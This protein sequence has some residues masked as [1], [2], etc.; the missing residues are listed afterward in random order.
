MRTPIRMVTD[1]LD[2][3]FG[4]KRPHGRFLE[5]R[6]PD[7][8]KERLNYLYCFGGITF[9]LFL[10]LLFTGLL[11]SVYYSPSEEHAYESIVR[12]QE[13]VF[14]GALIRAIHKWSANL[15]VVAMLVHMA[16][17]FAGGAYR[18]PRELTWVA[19]TALLVITL[20]FGFTG[21]LL[22]WNQKAYWATVVGTAMPGTLPLVGESLTL[23]FRG[24]ED[25]T[26][27]TLVRF[28]SIHTHWLPVLT[29]VMLWAHFHMIKR[30]GI[31]GGM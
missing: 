8:L 13:T 25:V 28:Y 5:R 26:G 18:H 17:V 2:R 12:I 21:Y 22:P 29:F 27:E 9:T 4:F 23:L 31:A 19:G 16:R 10:M 11:L 20:A 1:S 7:R 14:A 24:G 6:L 15:M 3:L 30:R